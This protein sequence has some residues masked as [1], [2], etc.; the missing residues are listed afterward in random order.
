MRTNANRLIDGDGEG[1]QRHVLSNPELRNRQGLLEQ[2][3]ACRSYL[4]RSAAIALSGALLCVV[5][6][7]IVTPSVAPL[8]LQSLSQ[9]CWG[10]KG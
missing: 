3:V 5:Y 2:G 1:D 4:G 6:A 8:R 9:A 10:P 7:S